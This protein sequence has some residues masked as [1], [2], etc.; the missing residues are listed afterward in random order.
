MGAVGPIDPQS[1]NMYAYCGNDPVNR[2][3]PDGLFWGKLLHIV[4]KA[5]QVVIAVVLT[6]IAI[7]APTLPTIFQAAQAWMDVFGLSKYLQP[8]L[9]GWAQ[10][11]GLGGPT[12]A[13]IGSISASG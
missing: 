11:L 3:D 6:V 4:K 8:K 10:S 1:L 9:P 12:G 2:T 13:G 7:L 5:L